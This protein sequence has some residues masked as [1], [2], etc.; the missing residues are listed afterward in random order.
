MTTTN[1]NTADAGAGAD[2]ASRLRWSDTILE[3]LAATTRRLAR[4]LL[5][6]LGTILGVAAFV[7][8]TGLAATASAQ[9]SESFDALKATE[10]RIQDASPDGTNPFP[11]NVDQRLQRLNGV[12]HA[13]LSYPVP[14]NGNLTPRNTASRPLGNTTQQI[15][16]IAATPGALHAARPTLA[17]GVLFNQF[18]LD[19]AEPVAVLG[20]VAATQLGI[21]RIDNQPA[22]FIGDTG[23]TVVGIIGDTA[24]NADILLAAIIPTTTEHLAIGSTPDSLEVLIDTAPGAAQLI[25]RQ[26]LLALRSQQ[27]ERLAALVPPD[28]TTLRDGVESDVTSLYYALAALSLAVGTIAIANATLLSTIERSPEIGLRRALG[29]K[30]SHITRQIIVEASA[31]GTV[32]GIAG[33]ALAIIIVAAV[34]A[35]RGWTTT[36]DPSIIAAAPLIGLLTGAI[37]GALPAMRA[38]R[39]PPAVTLRT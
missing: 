24:R 13:G 8:T 33:T 29:A 10:V 35:S 30:R 37:A 26:A 28:P 36:I 1:A 20:R 7:T 11:D 31:T 14:D 4:T 12:N 6:A 39:T 27:P 2:L 16:I 38:S 18:H 32:A 15:P 5:T 9:V 21:T 23:Y 17:T 34:A 19:R 22:V 25:G 3:A